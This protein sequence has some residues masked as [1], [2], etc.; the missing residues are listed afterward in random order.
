[1]FLKTSGRDNEN[2]NI[3]N[4]DSLN[5]RG[6]RIIPNAEAYQDIVEDGQYYRINTPHAWY[7]ANLNWGDG[8]PSDHTDEPFQISLNNV[9][10]HEYEKPETNAWINVQIIIK[11]ILDNLCLCVVLCLLPLCSGASL[12]FCG[13]K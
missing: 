5:D 13:R 12:F 1:M 8:T 9:F 6:M 11:N 10:E 7:V 2:Y 3:K 4:Y